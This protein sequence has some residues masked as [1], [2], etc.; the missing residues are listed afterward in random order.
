M[1][2]TKIIQRCKGNQ[3]GLNQVSFLKYMF[4][5]SGQYVDL[6]SSEGFLVVLTQVW[7]RF[8]R[9][10]ATSPTVGLL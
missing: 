3:G 1:V 4:L 8:Q 7:D 10:H 9:P 6:A 2:Y 5:T